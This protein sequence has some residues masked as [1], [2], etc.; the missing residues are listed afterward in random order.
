MITKTAATQELDAGPAASAGTAGPV[1]PIADCEGSGLNVRTQGLRLATGGRRS[2]HFS[3]A[4]LSVLGRESVKPAPAL[5]TL[6]EDGRR[7]G[8]GDGDQAEGLRLGRLPSR[9]VGEAAGQ[10]KNPIALFGSC[11]R[12]RERPARV[13]VGSTPDPGRDRTTEKALQREDSLTESSP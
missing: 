6:E 5:F 10:G 13:S 4:P 1:R 3:S 11:A 8:D 2:R 7:P 9:V 12:S